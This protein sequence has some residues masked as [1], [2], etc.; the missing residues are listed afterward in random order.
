MFYVAG[1]GGGGAGLCPVLE[2]VGEGFVVRAVR[3][4]GGVIEGE[5]GDGTHGH[6]ATPGG[7][8]I[9]TGSGRVR[10]GG[11]REPEPPLVPLLELD[12]PTRAVGAALRVSEPPPVDGSVTGFDTSEPLRLDLED[13]Y[14]RSEEP[15]SGPEDF[16]AAAFAAWDDDALYLAV[17]VT[18][19]DVCFRPPDAPPLRL[20]NE[21][22]DVHSDGLQLYLRDPEGGDVT[23]FLV[24][25]EGKDGA[26][27]RARGAG[28]TPGM[29]DAIRGTWRR[30]REGYR[31]TLARSEEHTS[32]LQSRLHLVC[33]LLLEKK[34][35]K[36]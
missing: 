10:L 7:G 25:P 20:D 19:P 3:T 8:E 4:Q 32:E 30:T 13:Q 29:P 28:E 26:R 6:A 5:T 22:D 15:Y 11:P 23:G 18:K 16:S 36:S 1:A 24:V 34:K 14:R 17:E 12:R 35:N 2:R 21:P 33:R 9:D 27:L 31:V